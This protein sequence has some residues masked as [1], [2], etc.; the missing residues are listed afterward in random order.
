MPRATKSL[1][2]QSTAPREGVP[3]RF[4]TWRDNLEWIAVLV[5][6]VLLVRQ[7]V[8]EAFSIKHG[9][10]A[11][12][13]L[14]VHQEVRC[15]NCGWTFNVGVQKAGPNGEVE[16]PNCTY[17][18]TGA[19]RWDESGRE[20][21]FRRPEWLWN[22]GRV[23]RRVVTHG[24]DAANRVYRGPCR[25]FV[26]KV[27]Y[28]LR[29]P[30]RWEVVVFL[31]PL[32][33]IRCEIC[34]NQW[35]APVTPELMCPDCG[36]TELEITPRDFIKRVVGLPGEAISIRDGDVYVDGAIARK[37]PEVQRRMWLHV[38]DS[39]FMPRVENPPL[40]DLSDAPDQWR[41]ITEGGVLSVDA[42]GETTPVM[43][44]FGRPVR[45][46]YPYGGLSF[47]HGPHLLGAGGRN[48]VGDCRL[49]A[50]VRLTEVD[51]SGGEVLLGIEDAGHQLMLSVKTAPEME[52]ALTD[53]GDVVQAA[54]ADELKAGGSVWVT[55]ENYDDRVVAWLGDRRL[56]TYDY[57][58]R[59]GGRQALTFGARGARVLW[60]RVLVER[61]VH[62]TVS[63]DPWQER[64]DWTLGDD[65][66]FVL[67]DNS[68]ASSDSRSWPKAGV[69][70]DNLI[71][72]AFFVLW[73]V[74]YWK[75]L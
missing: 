37:P 8:V 22:E 41:R 42:Q 70:S 20:A 68:P 35:E 18:W 6:V 60:E 62:Y 24:S 73:P 23:G 4:R 58:G 49:R 51:P 46:I 64:S 33:Q 28:R 57:T 17:E 56:F 53:D 67:G 63:G 32:H 26:N 15:P 45:D 12:T 5:L 72:R 61:D 75:W 3:G 55:L 39:R 40:F 47:Q 30:R 38:F 71:G 29:D 7:M 1:K 21:T 14:G 74:H 27:L 36:S 11:P 31:Y 69:P 34:G 50:K 10:M 59:P 43:A 16:C 44:S 19:A 66:Y 54:R 65:E 48:S 13:L 25:V 2:P 52:A 9:S